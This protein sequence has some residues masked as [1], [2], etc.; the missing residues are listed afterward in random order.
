[1]CLVK[2]EE[3]P[4]GSRVW[5]NAFW[6]PDRKQMVYGQALF[7]NQLRSLASALAVVA[8][9]MFHGVTDHTAKLQYLGASGARNESYSDI[10]GVIV[11]NFTEPDISKWDWLIG[12]GISSGLTA[13]RDFQDPT[14]FQQPKM[15][16]DYVNMPLDAFSDYGGVHTNS[17]IHNFAAY[18]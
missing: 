15:M 8:H 3:R 16:A 13:L 2:A 9:E 10:F 11:A 18:N 7:N 14:R 12:D 17:G 4:P 6:D 1:N 5:L